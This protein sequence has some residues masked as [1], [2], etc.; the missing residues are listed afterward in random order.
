MV[1]DNRDAVA[2]EAKPSWQDDVA[3]WVPLFGRIE[4]PCRQT[5]ARTLRA[6]ADILQ[7]LTDHVYR[8]SRTTDTPARYIA[9]DLRRAVHVATYRMK[10]ECGLPTRKLKTHNK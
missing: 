3:D 5:D 7:D 1:F 9:S 10:S 4:V 6:I 8:L 2:R